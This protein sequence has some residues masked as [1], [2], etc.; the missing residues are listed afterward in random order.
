M[1]LILASQSPYRRLQLESF[2]VTFTA[3]QPKV[4]ESALKA[5]GPQNPVD[6]TTYLAQ[7]KAMSLAEDYPEAII[8]GSDQLAELNGQRLDKPGSRE[9]ARQQ[10]LMLQGRSH[11]LV[12]SLAA[13]YRGQT[14]T[15]TNI[16][17]IRMRELDDSAIEAYL[18]LDQ[19]FDCAGSYKIEKAG[20]ALVESLRTEDPSALQGLPLISLTKALTSLGIPL[21]RFWRRNET[22]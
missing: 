8:I 11:R 3:L 1:Q 18:N 21:S 10:L 15:F 17:E 4:D 20:L 7:A 22:N 12:T 16:T 2:G 9:R 6:L 14:Q 13:H 5:N 19:P